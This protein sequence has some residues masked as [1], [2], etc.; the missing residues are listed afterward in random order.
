MDKPYAV[1]T[2]YSAT[3]SKDNNSGYPYYYPS[4]LYK[5]RKFVPLEKCIKMKDKVF[6]RRLAARA[7][8]EMKLGRHEINENCV[9]LI[10]SPFILKKNLAPDYLNQLE[11][12]KEIIEIV[13]YN[14]KDNQIYF[15]HRILISG[16]D[17]KNASELLKK[18][19]KLFVPLSTKGQKLFHDEKEIINEEFSYCSKKER[20]S[21]MSDAYGKIWSHHKGKI[22]SIDSF[23]EFVK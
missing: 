20:N 22:P 15:K 12:S 10:N 2:L 14:S 1:L 3:C 17:S 19:K 21:K 18:I 9:N 5:N 8:S 6:N 4:L 16:Y 23:V 7:W 13:D 11:G